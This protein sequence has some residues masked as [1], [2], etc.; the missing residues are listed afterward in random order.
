MA[1]VGKKL[2]KLAHNFPALFSSRR[3]AVILLLI[4][5]IS[6]FA[7]YAYGQDQG[8]NTLS[9]PEFGNFSWW[10]CVS[11]LPACA[12]Y[13]ITYA[14]TTILALLVALGALLTRVALQFNDNLLDSPAV[15]AGFGVALSVA[16]L[17]FVLGIII[18]A[19]ATILHRTTYG[20][21]QLLS[22]LIVMAILVNFSLVISG[23]ILGVNSSFTQY[24]MSKSSPQGDYFGFVDT[25]VHAFAPNV[26]WQPPQTLNTTDTA[27]VTAMV[28]KALDFFTSGTMTV[29]NPITAVSAYAIKYFGQ[30]TGI[31][32]A[33]AAD[34][35]NT[36]MVALLNMIFSIIFVLIIA[37]TYLT[38][39]ILLL[40]RYVFITILLILAPLAW[41]TWVFPQ[42]SHLNT[43]WWNQFIRWTFFPAIVVFF[44]YL[45]ITTAAKITL[46]T[47]GIVKTNG[48]G[49][50]SVPEAAIISMTGNPSTMVSAMGEIA[51]LGLAIGGLFAANSLSITGASTAIGAA[52]AVGGAVGGWAGKQGKKAGRAAI[53]R[54]GIAERMQRA[55]IPVIG[56]PI[57]ALG[58]ALGG[59]A[60]AGGENLVKV[61]EEKLKNLSSQ[62]I[63]TE[64]EGRMPI[65]KQIANIK[66]LQERGDLGEIKTIAGKNLNDF[67]KENEKAFKDYGQQKLRGDLDKSRLHTTD[68]KDD[69]EKV[70]A[71]GAGAAAAL[72]NLQAAAEKLATTISS[73]DIQ[74]GQADSLFVNIN[75]EKGR[76][77]QKAFGMSAGAHERLQIETAG[78][79][80]KTGSTQA[81]SAFHAKLAKGGNQDQ[82]DAMMRK[83]VEEIKRSLN[84][85][86][87]PLAPENRQALMDALFSKA[88]QVWLSS[89]AGQNMGIDV[90][91]WGISVAA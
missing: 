71:G 81:F 11:N 15:Q 74:K 69:A 31:L 70:A 83:K 52:K 14:I 78:A 9:P 89:Q 67:L 6:V 38:L 12:I 90:E 55:K 64:L 82:F 86:E 91:R 45:A 24:F 5:F 68:M 46:I 2:K 4:L 39:A 29:V 79:I 26:F 17:G 57:T 3:N 75:S 35:Q 40:V 34:T 36:F 43:K 76:G 63:A 13:A 56:R 77:L 85:P 33:T 16:N 41:L 19:L 28:N 58:R 51:I 49:A 27:S 53:Q 44:L 65:E 87:G 73:S 37:F 42:F 48:T 20:I 18:I 32:P 72:A 62:A 84:I 80:G 25:L 59:A 60:R 23:V 1:I 30:L 47:K 61:E 22:K 7:N 88:N 10:S 54:T 21:K 50:S 66:T 8:T